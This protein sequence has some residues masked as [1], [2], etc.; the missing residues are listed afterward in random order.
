MRSRLNTTSRPEASGVEPPT[1]PV[2][3][4]CGTTATLFAAHNATTR[5]TS[6]VLA[7]RTTARA[8]PGKFRRQSVVYR[9]VSA[10]AVN[11]CPGPTMA[12]SA[13]ARASI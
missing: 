1:S 11:T 8:T 5:D 9:A 3:P 12:R 2:L 6:R 7:G 10:S 13:V 4:P